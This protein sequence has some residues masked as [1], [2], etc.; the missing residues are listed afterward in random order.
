MTVVN[1]KINHVVL[2]YDNVPQGVLS[3]KEF[4]R[5]TVPLRGDVVSKDFFWNRSITPESLERFIAKELIPR[6][7]DDMQ[8]M[9]GCGLR[10]VLHV[11]Y[12][13]RGNEVFWLSL[14]SST[15]HRLAKGGS[16]IDI[17]I[18]GKEKEYVAGLTATS[19][20]HL[21]RFKFSIELA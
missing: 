11:D 10:P 13:N 15:V 2:R 4:H 21:S 9:A 3:P 20:H 17:S 8:R 7:G 14:N 16:G 19:L 12:V 1:L 18:R 6:F 5:R